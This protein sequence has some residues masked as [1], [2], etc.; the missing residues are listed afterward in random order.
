MI[1]RLAAHRLQL[2]NAGF[3]VGEVRF[4]LGHVETSCRS[5]F[6][7]ILGD[8]ETSLLDA[9][10]FASKFETLLSNP[11]VRI[12]LGNFGNEKNKHIVVVFH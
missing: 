6:K 4:G 3:G 7:P 1:D 10:V 5:F 9:D 11:N 8:A 12:G 2:E